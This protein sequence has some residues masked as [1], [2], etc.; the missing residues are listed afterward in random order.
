MSDHWAVHSCSRSVTSLFCH[1]TTVKPLFCS[2]N[3]VGKW[4]AIVCTTNT[5]KR[6]SI[7]NF[8]NNMITWFV[9][10]MKQLELVVNYATSRIILQTCLKRH[11]PFII[12]CKISLKLISQINL[13][14]YYMMFVS[15]WILLQAVLNWWTSK[16]KLI[17]VV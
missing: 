1:T 17:L 9:N 6:L 5:A 13:I 8:W 12:D 10:G 3:L 16:L 7:I 14:P 11:F 4:R 15:S 2:S